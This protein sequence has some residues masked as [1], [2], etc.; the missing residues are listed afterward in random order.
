MIIERRNVASCSLGPLECIVNLAS[1][2]LQV[3]SCHLWQQINILHLSANLDN[4]LV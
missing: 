1:E 3:K 2:P 4:D